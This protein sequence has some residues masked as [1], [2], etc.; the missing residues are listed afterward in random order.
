M[1]HASRRR[2]LTIFVLMFK[3]NLFG[4]VRKKLYLCISIKHNLK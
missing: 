3:R 4:S 2:A 1:M